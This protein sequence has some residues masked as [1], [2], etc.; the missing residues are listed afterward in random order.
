MILGPKVVPKVESRHFTTRSGKLEG[1]GG[2]LHRALPAPSSLQDTCGLGCSL[3][4]H[5]GM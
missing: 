4:S 5:V 2:Q 3:V 1:E